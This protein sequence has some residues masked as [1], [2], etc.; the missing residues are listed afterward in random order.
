M[1]TYSLVVQVG[2]L[3]EL[4]DAIKAYES[5]KFYVVSS[6]IATLGGNLSK[7]QFVAILTFSCDRAIEPIPS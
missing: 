6:S 5:K 1:K 4:Q 7:M 2:T 3:K